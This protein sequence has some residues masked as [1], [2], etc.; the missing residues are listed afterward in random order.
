MGILLCSST[1]LNTS[2]DFFFKKAVVFSSVISHGCQARESD[3]SGQHITMTTKN[4]F[5]QRVNPP[6]C[7]GDSKPQKVPKDLK[8]FQRPKGSIR[9]ARDLEEL[10][11]YKRKHRLH[12]TLDMWTNKIKNT[13]ISPRVTRCNKS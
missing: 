8:G 5:S 12:K 10:D 1:F 11:T 13:T 7:A 2:I 4:L 3:T 6:S 9:I